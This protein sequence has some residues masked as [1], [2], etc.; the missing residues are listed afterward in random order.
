MTAECAVVV[1]ADEDNGIGAGNRLPWRIPGDM[2]FFRQ[3]TSD[4]PAG[5]RNAVIMGRKTYASIPPKFRPLAG[6]LNVVLSRGALSVP[7]D[8]VV[9]SSFEAALAD[10][11]AR[12]DIH[13]VFVAGGG[14][15]YALA[16]GHPAC[17]AVYL[18]RVHARFACDTFLPGLGQTFA[19]ESEGPQQLEGELAFTFQ[20]YVRQEQ[21]SK[22]R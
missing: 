15:I 20:H 4:A 11:A 21:R 22:A 7:D 5:M 6:R 12:S 14:E 3:L 1:A 9:L 13:R 10:C 18:T 2:A 8:V 19:L 16:L 17:S